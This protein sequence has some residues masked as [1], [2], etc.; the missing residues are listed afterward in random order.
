MVLQSIQ[1]G[2][3]PDA[4]MLQSLQAYTAAA[5]SGSD[6]AVAAA[7]RKLP[8]T[9]PSTNHPLVQN[10]PTAHAPPPPPSLATPY[11]LQPSPVSSTSTFQPSEQGT[12]ATHYT[13]L[14]GPSNGQQH[15]DPA[16]LLA[17]RRADLGGHEAAY[18]QAETRTTPAPSSHG[19][20]MLA[21]ASLQAELDGR[22][23]I[24]PLDA[25]F[26]LSA[27]TNALPMRGPPDHADRRP[28]IFDPLAGQQPPALLV[29]RIID[30]E[31]TVELFRI[32]FDL[33]YMVRRRSALPD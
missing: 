7:A 3:T 31:M 2:Q 4:A 33:C 15:S 30:P 26:R 20:D 23:G 25:H 1:G 16:S 18:T 12:P 8:T 10:R 14:G 17:A 11:G 21:S 22:K 9:A 13:P 24:T 6:D 27:I 5:A 32:F 28:S 19:I 29:K